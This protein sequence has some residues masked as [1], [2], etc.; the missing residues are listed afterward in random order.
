MFTVEIESNYTKVVS[1]DADG[2]FE[3][4]EM[5]LEDDGTCFIRQFCDELN[6][7]QLIAINYKQVLDLMASLDA[8]DGVYITEVGGEQ[9]SH[10]KDV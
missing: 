10:L 1:V 5:Y 4:V 7:F 9:G 6:E 3:D 2:K 8:H